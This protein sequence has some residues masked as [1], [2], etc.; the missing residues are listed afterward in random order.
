[1]HVLAF[2]RKMKI[3]VTDNERIK[4]NRHNVQMLCGDRKLR[5]ITILAALL[6]ST[7]I[8]SFPFHV[9]SR[10]RTIMRGLF[11]IPDV[12]TAIDVA[13]V[14]NNFIA[15]GAIIFQ[16][17]QFKFAIA[18]LPRRECFPPISV[19]LFIARSFLPLVRFYPATCGNVLSHR[20]LPLTTAQIASSSRG[21]AT[22]APAC[23][24]A[25]SHPHDM[26][27]PQTL[28]LKSL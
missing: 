9:D 7:I 22:R 1:M 21:K 15:R 27:V 16:C 6:L 5:I 3:K 24:H 17:P 12:G 19:L 10:R 4:K 11:T 2:R 14:E 20:P 28:R 26:S 8:I 13:S 23:T 18:S 25:R